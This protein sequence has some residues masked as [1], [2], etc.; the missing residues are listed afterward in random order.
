VGRILGID[1]GDKRIGL[2]LSD[3]LKIFAAPLKV[4]EGEPALREELKRLLVESEI[5][6]IVVGLPLNM[7]GSVGPKAR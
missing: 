5:E 6:R 3:P 4:V 1:F 7:D 2:A